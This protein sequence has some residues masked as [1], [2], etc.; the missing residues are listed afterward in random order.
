[1][2]IRAG[3][4][5][6]IERLIE[7]DAT[8]ESERYLHVQREGEGLA[9]SWRLEERAL[10]EKRVD[11]NGASDDLRFTLKQLLG[12]V[13]EGIVLAAEHEGQLVGL[14]AGRHNLERKTLD[15]IDVRVDYDLRREGLGIAMLF[16]MIA[17]ARE[18]GVRA[19][20]ATTQTNN[21]PAGQLLLKGGFDLCGVDTHL[22]SNHDLVKEAVAM[23]WYAAL[24]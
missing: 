16:Q 19:V 17:K 9:V 6:D 15:V 2:Q 20:T 23:F 1:M 11:N 21:L 18:M 5:Q 8:I 4:P 13:E 14:A 10:R 24:D 3:Q 22:N 12:G 7:L